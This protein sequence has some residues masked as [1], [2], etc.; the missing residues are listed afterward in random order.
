MNKPDI[1][2]ALHSEAGL[3][4]TD[5]ATV[6]DLFFNKMSDALAK[7]ERIEL[8][9]LS[10]FYVKEYPGY[11][12]RNPKTGKKAKIL[13]KQLPFFKCGKE[14]KDRVDRMNEHLSVDRSMIDSNDEVW[15]VWPIESG[16]L[17]AS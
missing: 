14:L 16:L 8:R 12:S 5:A 7:G 17:L 1:I 13:P 11:T 9:G 3:T 10:S 15:V 4:K 2:E 6:I